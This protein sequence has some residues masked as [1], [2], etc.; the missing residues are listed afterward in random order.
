MVLFFKYDFPWTLDIWF[1]CK[2][3]LPSVLQ[4]F[5]S[6]VTSGWETCFLEDGFLVDHPIFHQGRLG[7]LPWLRGVMLSPNGTGAVRLP[8]SQLQKAILEYMIWLV[9]KVC[10]AVLHLDDHWCQSSALCLRS[11]AVMTQKVLHCHRHY[12]FFLSSFDMV[13]LRRYNLNKRVSSLPWCLP[14]TLR[15]RV[16]HHNIYNNPFPS[17][18]CFNLIIKIFFS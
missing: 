7:H 6:S 5:R 15:L 14:G 13:L 11:M 16:A 9:P 2:N 8:I 1:I 12:F 18:A 17:V 3:Y 4:S 10:L